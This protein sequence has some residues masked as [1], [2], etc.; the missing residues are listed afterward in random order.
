[1][2][3]FKKQLDYIYTHPKNRDMLKQIFVQMFSH[4]LNNQLYILFFDDHLSSI[5]SVVKFSRIFIYID[6][7]TYEILTLLF[8]IF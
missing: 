3:F 8:V 2:Y 5:V 6:L 7:P 1:M 4:L